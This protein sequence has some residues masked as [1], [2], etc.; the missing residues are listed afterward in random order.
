MVDERRCIGKTVLERGSLSRHVCVEIIRT[1]DCARDGID[2]NAQRFK[3]RKADPDSLRRGFFL[4]DI[5]CG[6][7][8]PVAR[9]H[10][11]AARIVEL[12]FC[13]L[14]G[15]PERG[16]HLLFADKALLKGQDFRRIGLFGQRT[17]DLDGLLDPVC[18]EGSRHR[19]AHPAFLD[20]QAF[21]RI[22]LRQRGRAEQKQ[23]DKQIND[24]T[25][26]AGSSIPQRWAR[27]HAAS[28]GPFPASRCCQSP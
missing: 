17:I 4:R 16:L 10:G 2:R 24:C 22:V 28:A 8:T 15:S 5:R 21:E 12:S 20:R 13:T 18:A 19:T 23:K 1:A 3:T 11:I 25:L 9:V 27:Q 14:S 6:F 26:H 7:G